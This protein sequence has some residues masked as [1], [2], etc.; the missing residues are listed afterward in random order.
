MQVPCDDNL[1]AECSPNENPAIAQ[2]QRIVLAS[3]VRDDHRMSIAAL[4]QFLSVMT[5][6]RIASAHNGT[7]RQIKPIGK[8]LA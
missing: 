1:A 4:R 2:R 6:A 3:E 7:I 8:G 5:M